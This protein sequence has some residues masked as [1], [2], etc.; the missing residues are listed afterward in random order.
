MPH[1]LL[2]DLKLYIFSWELQ[3]NAEILNFN[4]PDS[5]PQCIFMVIDVWQNQNSFCLDVDVDRDL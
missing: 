3:T 5:V 4:K 1:S 2:Q